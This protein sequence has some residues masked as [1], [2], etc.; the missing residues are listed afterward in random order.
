MEVNGHLKTPQ[1]MINRRNYLTG[2][3]LMHSVS[4]LV[5]LVL[6]VLN[7]TA[8][9]SLIYLAQ[10]VA[11]DRQPDEATAITSYLMNLMGELKGIGQYFTMCFV[12][13]AIKHFQYR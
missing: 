8:D 3:A 5:F 13:L 2:F 10:M 12:P 4:R 7:E 11:T 9:I 6:N 1:V